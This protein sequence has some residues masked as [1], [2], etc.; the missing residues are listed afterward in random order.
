PLEE[1]LQ[2]SL[3]RL[4]QELQPGR[5]IVL[6]VPTDNAASI[7]ATLAADPMPRTEVLAV[8]DARAACER[9]GVPL[10][11]I[12]RRATTAP[13]DARQTA[14]RSIA[15]RRSSLWAGALALLVVAAATAYLLAP[16][17]VVPPEAER[18]PAPREA[19]VPEAIP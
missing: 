15:S 7:K 13:V 17:T 10:P 2:H 19:L 14:A 18:E 3:P 9:L 4:K 6:A 8:S 12:A 1:K 11:D 5:R 16:S